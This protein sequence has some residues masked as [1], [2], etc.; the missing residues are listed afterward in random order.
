M[1]MIR[2]N[3]IAEK[4]AGAPKVAKKSSRQPTWVQDNVILIVAGLI[5]IGLAAYL[6]HTVKKELEAK[7]Q[8]KAE[9]QKTYNSLKIWETK[10]EEFEIRR[11]L[12]IEKIQKISDLKENRDGPVKLM[13]DVANVLPESVW[14]ASI[15][16]GYD[17]NL[18]KPSR[19][20]GKAA[21]PGS[22]NIGSSRLIR[23]RGFARTTDAITNLARAFIKLDERYKK[24]DLNNYEEVNDASG[25]FEFELFFELEKVPG[26]SADAEKNK[27]DKKG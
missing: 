24:T 27:K 6:F 2:I 21:K 22:K 4:K 12:L 7:V 3:L 16:Q 17:S 1:T 9:L 15:A 18:V 11:Q 10:K 25:Q 20:G 5:A 14:L 26:E 19:K 8:E 23:I 13:E